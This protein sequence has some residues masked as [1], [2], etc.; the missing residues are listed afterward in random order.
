VPFL[1]RVYF[2]DLSYPDF[3]LPSFLRIFSDSFYAAKRSE[4]AERMLAATDTDAATTTTTEDRNQVRRGELERG[5]EEE[6]T[7]TLTSHAAPSSSSRPSRLRDQLRSEL[8]AARALEDDHG[9]AA[10]V[11]GQHFEQRLLATQE[12]RILSRHAATRAS[13]DRFA[14]R[15]ARKLGVPTSELNLSRSD[16]YRTKVE[17]RDLI[18]HTVPQS[19]KQG[20]GREESWSGSLRG[21]GHAYI[22]VGNMFSGL[23]TRIT[24][25]GNPKI[26]IVRR[27]NQNK[28]AT[29]TQ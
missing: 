16:H 13:W 29:P 14:V 10:G 2:S 7:F 26:E 17:L 23:H 18:D 22:S 24:E 20:A 19:E 3:A 25:R 5:Q 28:I 9:S 8:S 27:P 12:E 15:A 11:G 6:K 21:I 4:E 1:V